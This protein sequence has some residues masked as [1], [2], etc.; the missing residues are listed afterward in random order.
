VAKKEPARVGAPAASVQSCRPDI[1]GATRVAREFGNSEPNSI[2]YGMTPE[3]RHDPPSA[4]LIVKVAL[5][6]EPATSK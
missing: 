3:N 4:K 5:D 2:G 6:V 1:V